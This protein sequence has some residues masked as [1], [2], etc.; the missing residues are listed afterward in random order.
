M[1]ERAITEGKSTDGV[2]FFF[3]FLNLIVLALRKLQS[4]LL[5]S[6]KVGAI[7]T[8]P[9]NRGG[10]WARLLGCSL[11]ELEIEMG[12]VGSIEGITRLR[13][14]FNTSWLESSS[15]SSLVPKESNEV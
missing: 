4:K 7:S 6:L 8:S 2:I 10:V 9:M 14:L 13:F 3:K 5:V 1:M 15:F 12:T 11:S